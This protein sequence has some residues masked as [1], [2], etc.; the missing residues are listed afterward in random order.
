MNIST[1]SNPSSKN[2]VVQ[3]Q[4]N[5][6]SIQTQAEKRAQNKTVKEQ[7]GC[8]PIPTTNPYQIKLT[9][10]HP[11]ARFRN[12]HFRSHFRY[13]M[14]LRNEKSSRMPPY[15]FSYVR[16][17]QSAGY[18]SAASAGRTVSVA[19]NVLWLDVTPRDAQPLVTREQ[20]PRGCTLVAG[21]WS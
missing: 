8:L 1:H 21:S 14:E 15:L 7:A 16:H 6:K 13:Q 20:M 3:L 10:S 4:F 11:P 5:S 17:S 18:P 19:V 9:T 12:L 2:Q